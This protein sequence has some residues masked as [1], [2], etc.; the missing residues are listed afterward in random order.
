[1]PVF[2]LYIEICKSLFLTILLYVQ[3]MN[4]GEG[5]FFRTAIN[6]W[7]TSGPSKSSSSLRCM[8][9]LPPPRHGRGLVQADL[10]TLQ[11]NPVPN[12]P[13]HIVFFV[14]RLHKKVYGH[15]N[16]QQNQNYGHPAPL[17]PPTSHQLLVKRGTI[18]GLYVILLTDRGDSD[19]CE[20]LSYII[21]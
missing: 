6:Y 15:R 12:H 4:K 16:Y 11:P 1:M 5:N 14:C 17:P 3:V 19:V 20:E 7:C 10:W 2:P 13:W 9:L 21:S 18:W 8:S